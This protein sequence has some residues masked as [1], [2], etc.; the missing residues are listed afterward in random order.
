MLLIDDGAV[1]HDANRA[2]ME[3]FARPREDVLGRMT[4]SFMHAADREICKQGL[5]AMARDGGARGEVSSPRPI[6]PRCTCSRTSSTSRRS[7]SRRSPGVHDRQFRVYTL[8]IGGI[9]SG[10]LEG[11]G[12]S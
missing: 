3:L 1:V 12:R 11:D 2:A 7:P 10:I 5:A 6:T 8:L 9:R 4:S